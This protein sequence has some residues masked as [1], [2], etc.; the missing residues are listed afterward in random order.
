M[1]GCGCIPAKF[2]FQTQAYC[3]ILGFG[4]HVVYWLLILAFRILA[5]WSVLSIIVRKILF[6]YKSDHVS[7]ASISLVPISLPMKAE[8][9]TEGPHSLV[10]LLLTKLTS[11]PLLSL[12]PTP[13]QPQGPPAEGLDLARLAPPTA[14]ALG[15]RP[16]LGTLSYQ[17]PG[18]SVLTAFRS[19]FRGVFPDHP[20]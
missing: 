17:M 8:F 11:P 12:W 16:L 3:R 19:F 7:S 13:R 5:S 18:A 6:R 4:L 1:S 9:H 15:G 10:P 20:V 2:Y 14:L